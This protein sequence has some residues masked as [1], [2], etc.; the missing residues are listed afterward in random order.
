MQLASPAAAAQLLSCGR[1]MRACHMTL[2]AYNHVVQPEL[3]QCCHAVMARWSGRE[4][5]QAVLTPASGQTAQ[6]LIAHGTELVPWLELQAP[7]PSE[8]HMAF[9]HLLAISTVCYMPVLLPLATPGAAL[10]QPSSHR[11]R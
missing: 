4:S 10:S 8:C 6:A 7:T 11:L 1:R 9:P 5:T 2:M 3:D